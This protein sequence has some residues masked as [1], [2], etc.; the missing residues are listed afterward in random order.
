MAL[1]LHISGTADRFSLDDLQTALS[2]RGEQWGGG[3]RG[4]ATQRYSKLTDAW[5]SSHSRLRSQ[6]EHD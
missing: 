4:V 5:Q 1:I 3:V 6:M 2:G